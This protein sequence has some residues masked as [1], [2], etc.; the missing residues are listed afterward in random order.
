M[1]RSTYSPGSICL[2]LVV[3]IWNL[4]FWGNVSRRKI[5][6]ANPYFLPFYPEYVKKY[7][8]SSNCFHYS[9]FFFLPE[10]S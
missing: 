3:V 4:D 9:Y 6:I 8:K 10:Y 2:G 7:L 1:L 5:E